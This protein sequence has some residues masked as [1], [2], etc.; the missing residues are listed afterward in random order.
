MYNAEGMADVK[1]MC[2]LA[3]DWGSKR[4]GIAISDPTGKFARPLG[5][6]NH[7]SRAEDAKK[8]FELSVENSVDDIILGVTYDDDN[9][10]TPNGRSASRLA[11]AIS[12]LFVKQVILWDE[13]FTTKEAKLLQIEKGISKT[14][15]RGHQDGMAAVMLLEDYLGKNSYE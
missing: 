3:I 9:I 8:I 7:I 14:S 2:I 12:M 5:V 15:R 1:P 10:L 6:I 11:D 13:S 4:I